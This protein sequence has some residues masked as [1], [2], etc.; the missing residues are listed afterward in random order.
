MPLVYLHSSKVSHRE[1][2]D[3]I[4][5]AKQIVICFSKD[6]DLPEWKILKVHCEA[7]GKYFYPIDCVRKLESNDF[8][9]DMLHFLIRKAEFKTCADSIFI[10]VVG[11]DMHTLRCL[12][13]ESD[14]VAYFRQL[15]TD[16]NI[17]PTSYFGFM[18]NIYFMTYGYT[19]IEEAFIEGFTEAYIALGKE[20]PYVFTICPYDWL[21]RSKA[22]G[23]IYGEK[24]FKNRFTMAEIQPEDC[25]VIIN[26][27]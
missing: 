6:F 16:L 15:F 3:F 18:K 13:T 12:Y 25:N 19:G 5:D 21:L 24:A 26:Y 2:T 14:L 17:I 20:A 1:I 4:H 10:Q 23:S 11:D 7:T 27:R 9:I 22:G 8:D